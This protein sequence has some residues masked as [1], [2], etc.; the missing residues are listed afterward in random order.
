M[1]VMW[2]HRLLTEITANPLRA[3]EVAIYEALAATL[4]DP[5]VVW[6]SRPWLGLT[7]TGAERDGEADF[8]I[9]SPLTGFLTLEVKGGAINFDAGTGAW[10]SEDRYGIV[11][12]IKDP[13][14]QAQSSKH[15]LLAKLK[16]DPAWTGQWLRMRHG[17]V[18]PHADV[19]SRAVNAAAPREIF[20]D[21]AQVKDLAAWVV[22]RLGEP[23]RAEREVP[24][25]AAG[26]R[27]LEN[28]LS[29]TIE[30]SM[31]M[32]AVIDDDERTFRQLT[33]RQYH[34]IRLLAEE[35][36]A[37][38][39][40]AAGTGKTVLAIEKARLSASERKRT[41]FT[42][43][44]RPL[45]DWV[46][47]VLDPHGVD[48][49]T[50][51]ELCGTAAQ[52]AG[53]L[54]DRNAPDIEIFN[55]L[56][57]AALADA[58]GHRDWTG[59]DTIIVD[60]GQ[61]FMSHWWPALDAA[62]ADQGASHFYVFYDDNQN[63]YSG[64]RGIPADAQLRRY[65]LTQNMRNTKRIHAAASRHYAGAPCQAVGP[66]GVEV[67]WIR[68]A[69]ERAMERALV[70]LVRRLT[71]TEG[72]APE[73]IGLIVPEEEHTPVCTSAC[74]TAGVDASSLDS[75][76][77]GR[78]TVDTIRRFKGLERPVIIVAAFE[79]VLKEP[80]LAYVAMSRARAALFVVGSEPAEAFLKAG[81]DGR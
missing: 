61:D 74:K 81:T 39:P 70:R 53:V 36:R 11:H 30:L 2:P 20:C 57:P 25:G 51:H 7:H 68:A 41:L 26:I 34:V 9:A 8:V 1:A 60:E 21:R 71:G 23:D 24:L 54:V 69:D 62:L 10:A 19:P 12:S 4:P 22:A 28:V 31:P 64:A 29:R 50:F 18:F 80:E 33:P 77:S 58:C 59:Y 32:A 76:A 48:V 78:I 72:V 38:I 66:E 42:C 79:A 15:V 73:E 5:W 37:G 43:L 27:L 47:S 65:P 45:A 16:E 49:M 67:H 13:I 46:R 52:R 63:V 14:Q 55:D 44:N 56:L 75:Q 3:A 6:Y 40:G 35:P 17:V